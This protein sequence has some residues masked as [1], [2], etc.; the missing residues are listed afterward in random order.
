MRWRS[1]AIAAMVYAF[2][3]TAI[4]LYLLSRLMSYSES[5]LCLDNKAD[6]LSRA[7]QRFY[8]REQEPD[9]DPFASLSAPPSP[10]KAK[11]KAA[12]DALKLS[13]WS[14]EWSIDT[15]GHADTRKWR[16][17]KSLG[18]GSEINSKSFVL[19]DRTWRLRLDTDSVHKAL[20]VMTIQAITI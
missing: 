9:G 12:A 11:A 7:C 16:G 15:R 5:C 2:L 6:F 10:A 18:G 20:G 3:S 1:F 19:K 14:C 13:A 8:D 4:S 17:G